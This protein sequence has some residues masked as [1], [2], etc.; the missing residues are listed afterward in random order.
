VSHAVNAYTAA[1]LNEDEAAIE[2]LEDDKEVA[3]AV[4]RATI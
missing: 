3:A 2:A 4:F 1:M